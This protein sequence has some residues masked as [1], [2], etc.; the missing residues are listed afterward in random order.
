MS[1]PPAGAAPESPAGGGDEA[2][3]SVGGCGALA[4]DVA[5]AVRGPKGGHG[6][7][8]REVAEWNIDGAAAP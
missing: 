2:V 1:S 5:F 6:G 4:L 3:G 8:S 7:V